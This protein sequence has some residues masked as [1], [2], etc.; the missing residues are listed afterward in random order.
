MRI[1]NTY[2]ILILLLTWHSMSMYGVTITGLPT[3]CTFVTMKKT[4]QNNRL[5]SIDLLFKDQS[6]NH[7]FVE[8]KA[9]IF[10]NQNFTPSVSNTNATFFAESLNNNSSR[11]IALENKLSLNNL[12]QNVSAKNA[13]S[14]LH[15]KP[16]VNLYNDQMYIVTQS[17]YPNIR[18]WD[19]LSN[20]NNLTELKEI[21]NSFLL[22]YENQHAVWA[23]KQILNKNMLDI[24]IGCDFGAHS[25]SFLFKKD[26]Y[27]FLVEQNVFSIP[28]IKDNVLPACFIENN[29]I[30]LYNDK[31]KKIDIFQ[32][33]STLNNNKSEGSINLTESIKISEV[34]YTANI[35]LNTFLLYKTPYKIDYD[36]TNKGCI[37]L[38]ND[39]IVKININTKTF[40]IVTKANDL[41]IIVDSIIYNHKNAY[42]LWYNYH[43]NQWQLMQYMIQ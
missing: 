25:K 22:S 12:L 28:L 9:N 40:S 18:F 24:Y 26:V 36:A 14:D 5:E 34:Q 8:I 6:K 38:Y 13:Q 16:I 23:K 30:A 7:Y 20:N 29:Y 21:S 37:L 11:H 17:S 4:M 10:Q 32:Y 1:I 33:A 19:S 27:G 2:Y 35:N 15:N 3:N 41:W 39:L 43:N 31:Y 42:V